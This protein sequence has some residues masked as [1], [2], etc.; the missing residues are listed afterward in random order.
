MGVTIPPIFE[1]KA[2]PIIKVFANW[3]PGSKVRKIGSITEKHKTGAATF[4]SHMDAKVATNIIVNSIA[5]LS[6]PALLKIKVAIPFA[7]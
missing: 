1:A 2:I 4:E 7:I 3:F 6:V 5:L